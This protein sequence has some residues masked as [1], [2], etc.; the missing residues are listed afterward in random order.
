MVQT[1]F[2]IPGGGSKTLATGWCGTGVGS[3]GTAVAA[4][5][6]EGVLVESG[7]EGTEVKRA[8]KLAASALDRFGHGTTWEV[9]TGKECWSGN[10]VWRGRAARSSLVK[11]HELAAAAEAG[12]R[13]LRALRGSVSSS[14]KSLS[15]SSAAY[16][17]K[18]AASTSSSFSGMQSGHIKESKGASK[19][20]TH[21]EWKGR[22]QVSHT[23]RYRRFCSFGSKHCAKA[24]FPHCSKHKSQH[25]KV[26]SSEEG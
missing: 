19:S 11:A 25:Q 24:Q 10:L 21:S 20:P 7:V 12:V 26:L 23:I 16:A 18:I 14:P 1:K 15:A 22:L 13:A 8:T 17:S 6:L 9:G 4:I 3:S 2:Y 5:E